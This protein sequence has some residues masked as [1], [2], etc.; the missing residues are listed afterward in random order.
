MCC[1]LEGYEEVHVP[2]LKAK[3]FD[4]NEVLILI[5]IHCCI[6]SC[7]FDTLMHNLLSVTCQDAQF[8]NQ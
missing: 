6:F 2:H 7:S 8:I 3:P 5:V 4:S 1:L